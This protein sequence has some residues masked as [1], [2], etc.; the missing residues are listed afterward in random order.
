MLA[1]GRSGCDLPDLG[2]PVEEEDKGLCVCEFEETFGMGQSKVSYHM[3]KLKD[4][5]L[6]VEEKRGKWSFYSLD[7]GAA[8][9]LLGEAKGLLSV[10]AR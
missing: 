10:E 1:E 8:E 2:V 4:A 6:V 5:A 7:P 3:R 9:A